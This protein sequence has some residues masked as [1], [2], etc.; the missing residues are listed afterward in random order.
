[1]D[2][3][4]P[5]GG[6]LTLDKVLGVT[7][8]TL[9]DDARDGE[10]GLRNGQPFKEPCADVA[11]VQASLREYLEQVNVL[12]GPVRSIDL[13]SNV[14]VEICR[15]VEQGLRRYGWHAL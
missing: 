10:S 14:D 11:R 4:D 6:S 7:Q 3:I 12:H 13:P 5:A 1:M 15:K 2:S 8:R 9:H